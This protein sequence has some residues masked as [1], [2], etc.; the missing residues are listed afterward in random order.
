[1]KHLCI[2]VTGLGLFVSLLFGPGCDRTSSSPTPLS[3]E[4]MPAAFAKA[5][6]QAKPEVKEVADQV[7]AAV[8]AQDYS[9]AFNGLQSLV[10]R[11]NLSK[12]QVSVTT[13]GLLTVNTLL[14]AAQAKGDA[15]AAETIRVYN[16]NK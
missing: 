5:F 11:P 7:V 4:E 9:K 1:M 15:K 13:R 10:G 8:Q 2:K 6:S 12:D 3:A 14:Q 16:K